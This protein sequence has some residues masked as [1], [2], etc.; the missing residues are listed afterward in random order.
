[1]ITSIINKDGVT[2][3]TTRGILHNFTGYLQ[4]KYDLIQVCD[5]CVTEM[6]MVWHRNLPTGWRNFLDTPNN[7]GGL[8][9]AVNKGAC[10]KLREEMTSA[11]NSLKV[12]RIA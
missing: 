8:K 11:C 3:T 10:T 7:A 4:S 5:A 6:E 12:T 2:Q 9:T 1:M